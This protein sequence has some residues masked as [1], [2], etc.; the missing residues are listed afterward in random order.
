MGRSRVEVYV[1]PS[2]RSEITKNLD[3]LGKFILDMGC[4]GRVEF[5][6]NENNHIT[7]YH[8]RFENELD[9]NKF[10]DFG[11]SRPEELKMLSPFTHIHNNNWCMKHYHKRGKNN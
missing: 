7:Y 6:T 11:H 2:S 5:F 3:I 8:I 10:A 1:P 9:K 4:N